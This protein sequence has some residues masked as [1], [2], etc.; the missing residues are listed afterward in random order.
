MGSFFHE[1]PTGSRKG[2]CWETDPTVN[3]HDSSL[4]FLPSGFGTPGGRRGVPLALI[5]RLG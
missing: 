1:R 4:F 3:P 5:R 2:G